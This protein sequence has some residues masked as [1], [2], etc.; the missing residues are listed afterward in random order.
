M[1]NKNI[2]AI[3]SA[4]FLTLPWIIIRFSGFSLTPPL[5]AFLSG[6]AIIGAAFL[7]SWAAETSEIDVPRSA[8]LAFV[9][10]IAVMPEYAVDIYFTW[11]AG[12]APQS[13]YVHYAVANMTGANRLLIG[14]GWSMVFLLAIF[15]KNNTDKKFVELD[16]SINL[17]ILFL[18]A[19]TLYAF[20]LYFK[21]DISIFDTLIFISLYI[22]YIILAMRSP[23]E[24]PELEGVPS[25]LASF[26]SLKRKLSVLLFFVFSGFIILISVESFS[27]G[28]IKSASHLGINPFLMVQWVAPL[29]SE[30]P[31]LI[32]AAYLIKRARTTASLNALISSKLNQWTLLIGTIPVVYSLSLGGIGALPLDHRQSEELL[33]TAAQSLFAIAVILNLR[34]SVPEALLILALF[35]V[36]FFIPGVGGRVELSVVYI[37]L[38]LILFIWRREYLIKALKGFS[39]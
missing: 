17:E 31:E 21:S 2:A 39:L 37:V 28:L 35:L 25:F 20:T 22:A 1:V 29:A 26:G 27:E 33:L 15:W 8:S 36:Q 18:L 23:H 38:S 11:Q 24:E 32:V 6:V 14:I 10:L 4:V 16:K 5:A 19:A 13:P 30:S 12:Q 9:A 3:G 34:V 7:L